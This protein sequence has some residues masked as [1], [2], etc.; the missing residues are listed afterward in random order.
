MMPSHDKNTLKEMCALYEIT[1]RALR[2]YEYI[3]LL[4]PEKV[5]R[6]RYYGPREHARIKLIL[7]ARRMEFPLEQIRKWLSLYDSSGQNSEQMQ[8]LVENAKDQVN[9][10]NARIEALQA[11]VKELKY[12]EFWAAEKLTQS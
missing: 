6:T 10:L 12:F 7:R 1:P 11:A 5:G 4:S 9:V 2:Y 3:E 8:M